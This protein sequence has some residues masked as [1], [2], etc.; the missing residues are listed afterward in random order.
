MGWCGLFAFV[1][2]LAANFTNVPDLTVF[3]LKKTFF[4]RI[5]WAT[6]VASPHFVDFL[7]G[8]FQIQTSVKGSIPP[9]TV[10]KMIRD[11]KVHLRYC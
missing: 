5:P 11:M 6:L 10:F 3:N 7:G 4:P 1:R 2:L 8:F 9:S